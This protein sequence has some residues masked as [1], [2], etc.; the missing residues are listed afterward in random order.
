[1]L[2]AQALD[3]EG[4]T[5]HDQQLLDLERLLQVVHRPE[6]HGLDRALDGGVRGH[7]ED[8][9]ALSGGGRADEL[10]DELEAGHLRHQVVDDQDVEGAHAQHALRI[11]RAGGGHALVAFLAQRAAQRLQDLLL[12]VDQ[13]H[14]AGGAHL[15]T[16]AV[17]GRSMR[18]S[19]PSEGR[20]RTLMAPPSA[21]TMF[22][23]MA[24]PSPVPVRRVV[25]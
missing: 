5:H 13:E 11:P 19:V 12:V 2:R 6:L 3:L 16:V 14:G 7:H 4:V 25:K 1:M 10:A 23:A 15:S 20:L 18:T 17:A 21:S 9:R 24:R 8:L 22:L